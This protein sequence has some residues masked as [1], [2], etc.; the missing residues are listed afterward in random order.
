MNLDQFHSGHGVCKLCPFQEIWN[1]CQFWAWLPLRQPDLS[2]FRTCLKAT[3]IK[4]QDNPAQMKP[5]WTWQRYQLPSS[6]AGTLAKC[7]AIPED[8]LVTGLQRVGAR[9]H[10]TYRTQLLPSRLAFLFADGLEAP[11]SAV[12]GVCCKHTVF[13]IDLGEGPR[14]QRMDARTNVMSICVP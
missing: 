1:T 6:L 14:K 3:D 11:L 2:R 10:R 4:T 13:K 8:L 12:P 5:F 7:D 9:C